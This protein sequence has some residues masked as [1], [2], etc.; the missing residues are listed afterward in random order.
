MQRISE[1]HEDRLEK[2]DGEQAFN[3]NGILHQKYE[4][5]WAPLVDT[6][7]QGAAEFLRLIL[8]KKP[9]SGILIEEDTLFNKILQ[10]IV[11]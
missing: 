5:Y 6:G 2:R 10:R 9:D 7:Y 11:S 3:E 4:Y 8:S 1:S